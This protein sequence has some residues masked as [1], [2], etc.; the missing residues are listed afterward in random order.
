MTAPKF[1]NK[2]SW[3]NIIYLVGLIFAVAVFYAKTTANDKTLEKIT[4]EV[5]NLKTETEVLKTELKSINKKLD[6]QN[7]LLRE[8]VFG[9]NR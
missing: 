2:I 4:P 1:D 8:L 5:E 3:G 9:K 7:D 6:E